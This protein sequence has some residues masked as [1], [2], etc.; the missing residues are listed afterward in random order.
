MFE[1]VDPFIGTD[2]TDLPPPQGLAATWWWPKPQVG[3]THPGATYPFGMVV[4]LRV[5]GGLP[6]R[7]RPVR[8][9]HR[10][11][12]AARSTSAQVAS[13][14]TPLP[15]VRHRR[16]P[17]VLQLL[18]R[19]PDAASPSTT[20]ASC[21]T[22]VDEAGRAGLLR[23]DARDRA[24]AARSRSAPSSAV[25]RYTFPAHRDARLVIDFSLG[26]LAIPYGAHGPAAGAPARRIGPGSPQ[27]E[28]VVE[29]A[30]LAV[31]LECRQPGL[32]PAALV[33]PAAHAGRHPPGLRPDPPDHAAPVRPDVASGRP[34]RARSSSCGSASRCAAS[35]RRGRTCARDCG[36][37][38]DAGFERR[39]GRDRH[40][41]ARAPGRDPGRHP[42]AAERRTVFAT[43][44]Y[45]SL[46]K[47]CFAPDESPFWP[48]D[49]PFVFDI[50]TMWDIYRTQLPLLTALVPGPGRRAGRTR[51]STSARRRATCRSATGWPVAPTGSP[52]RAARWP[53]R[54]SPTCA[55]SDLP[56]IDWDWA[57]VP[58]GQRPA[59]HV[60]RG[61]PAARASRTRSPTRSTSRSATTAPPVVARA[62][63]RQAS[64]PTSS[65]PLATRWVNAF[66]P[67]RPGCCV[68][69][70]FY[71]GGRWNYSFRLQHDMAGADRARRR[72]RA[73][74][75]ACSTRSSAS[76]R[77]PGDAAR[78]ARPASEELAV[79]LRAQPVRG[80]EQRAGHGGPLGLPLRRAARPDRRGGARRRA[81][82]SSAPVAA[83]CPATTTPAGSRSWYVWASP[84]AVPGRRA[85]PVPA[86]RPVLRP[87]PDPARQR[88]LA[89]DRDRGL[90][91][92]GA[93]W[94]AAVR[95]VRHRS[96][97]QPL[98]R[99]WLHRP[100]APRGRASARRARP[101]TVRWGTTHRPPSVRRPSR[102]ELTSRAVPRRRARCAEHH[103]DR[104]RT[105]NARRPT[106]RGTATAVT[107]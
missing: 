107:P 89:D 48:T 20:S 62:R 15:A 90:R 98:E 30:P 96:T 23:R 17:Q 35:T 58:P 1:Y 10:G 99:P 55:S 102:S 52:G 83:G 3:N 74:S 64:W 40:G 9:E 49:G 100:R 101:G 41:V 33:R 94:P 76:V 11:R 65:R 73:R 66:D 50:C 46:I 24:S 85:E 93:G 39:R 45:H 25:H 105:T 106:T 14:F 5:L 97:A 22:L 81:A 54:S 18:P 84:R 7:L 44:L 79:G 29:G 59:P 2:A 88:S 42:D 68:D 8:A 72:G 75:S 26:G 63:R 53:T 36:A 103:D 51:C 47:P 82:A 19:H 31:H 67:A 86:Q 6:H 27:G 32:A 80:A 34:S 61:L 43:A 87:S 69:S 4:G 37:R 56:G 21:G 38:S 60:R 16:D 95:P 71:E 13:G 28:I 92:A 57:L 91:R 104:T 70:T 78:R 77:R 12:A